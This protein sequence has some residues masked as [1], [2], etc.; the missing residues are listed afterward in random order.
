M[1]LWSTTQTSKTPT[2]DGLHI[3]WVAA[4]LEIYPCPTVPP[5]PG[6]W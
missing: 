3:M 2:Y 4:L 6:V 5:Q 1:T